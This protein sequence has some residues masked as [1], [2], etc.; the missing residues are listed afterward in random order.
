MLDVATGNRT[1]FVRIGADWTAK[2]EGRNTWLENS[3]LHYRVTAAR[4]RVGRHLSQP[5]LTQ[6]LNAFG[7]TPVF[8][9]DLK[10]PDGL[11]AEGGL[12]VRYLSSL[13]DGNDRQLSTRFQFGSL[14]GVGYLWHS[15]DL[16]LQVEHV[17]NG[18]IR[19]PNHGVNFLTLSAGLR[20]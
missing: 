13:Y 16:K 4:W 6:Y 20:F 15:L 19:K 5:H 11:Y 7:V 12:G 3:T 9:F 10:E 18:G 1:Q 14:A 8:R 2:D 17:S